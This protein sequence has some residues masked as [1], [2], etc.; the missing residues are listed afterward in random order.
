MRQ[1]LITAC[2]LV[3]SG[4]LS[5]QQTYKIRI[6]TRDAET[7]KPVPF[8]NLQIENGPGGTSDIEGI[9]KIELPYGSI[10]INSSALGYESDP[11]RETITA[12]RQL[13]LELRPTTATLETVTVTTDDA[14]ERQ[15]RPL[16]GVERL[17]LKE[18]AVLPVALGEV[19]VFR[20]LQ[21]ISG[22]NSAGEV[23]NG[24]SVRGGTI[25][26][27]LVLL[28]GAPI[29]T[30]THL[31]GLFS[32]FTP[33][34]VGGVDLYR[35]NIPAR[36][37]GRLSSVVDIQTRNP[38]SNNF[39]LS[40]GLGLISSRVT[41]ETPVTKDKRLKLL[42][43]GRAGFNDFI[44]GLVERLKNTQSNFVDG[45][46][47]LRYT[48]NENNIV[49]LSSFYSKDFYAIDLLNN[50]AGI[51]A[52]SNQY[53][54]YTLNGTL[55][56]LKVINDKLSLS[57]RLV[58]SDHQPNILFPQEDNS[59]VRYGSRIQYRSLQSALD[60]RLGSGHQLTGGFQLVHYKLNP[61]FLEPNGSDLLLAQQLDKEQAL[62]SS[63][64]LADEWTVTD[65]LRL[66]LGVRYTKFD[67]LGP[68]SVR[69]YPEGEELAEGTLLEVTEVGA[70]VIN[71]Y[72]GVEP[73]LGISYQLLPSTN[74]KASFAMTRQYL[75]NIYN[76]ATP[77]PTSRWKVSDNNIRPQRAQ[78]IS[79]GIYQLINGGDYE[80]SL[81][82]YYRKIDD[83]LEYK[84]GADFFLTPQV[85]TD[86]LQGEGRAYGIELSMKETKGLVTSQVNYSYARVQ[87]RVEGPTFNTQINRGEWYNG[88][89]D[90]PHTLSASISAKD[91]P[92][93]TFNLNFTL[94]TNRPYTAPNG[95]VIS[96]G[97]SVPLFLERNNDRLPVY[98]RLDFSWRI[99]N[100][101]MKK[102]RWTGDWIFTVYNL[103]GRKNI[104]NTYY[105]PVTTRP[106]TGV[107][108]TNPLQSFELTIFGAPIASLTYSFNFE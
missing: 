104:F 69:S 47:K 12:N 15:L 23:S 35:G 60:Y 20:G 59:K 8:V 17:T 74:V 70:G 31:F 88:Y 16:M 51:A 95:Y 42:A 93:N 85:E 36:F 99:H 89:F 28:D 4:M 25:D 55:D 66:S 49:T 22:V 32:V 38:T 80:F 63:L 6:F 2:L 3:F 40:G 43:A 78:I 71:S 53:D 103:Y 27:N 100:P 75:Q 61:G 83:L 81:E 54:Y 14:S 30:P 79:A 29:F 82:G 5:A 68:G 106:S 64:F 10:T 67:Q 90:Q 24:I 13:L 19:D 45:T 39:K 77:L 34:A 52:T 18:L 73:R 46:L 11:L 26:Q 65:K 97:L 58:S 50:F 33:D 1:L 9:W 48:P 105:V 56:W 84:P 21:T 101:K 44:F 57:S 7:E 94:Q 87:N 102:R 37:G 107:V 86:I 72:A 91:G 41:V 62:E 98:H 108:N 76:A 96:N 92:A